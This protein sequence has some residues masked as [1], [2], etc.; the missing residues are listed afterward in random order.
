MATQC[1]RRSSGKPANG[2]AARVPLSNYLTPRFLLM[3]TVSAG[4]VSCGSWLPFTSGCFA[5]RPR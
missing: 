4:N 1:R 3:K 2:L 5:I